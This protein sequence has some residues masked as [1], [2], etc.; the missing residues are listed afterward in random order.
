MKR[1]KLLSYL[2]IITILAFSFSMFVGCLP[3]I[4]VGYV[5][6]YYFTMAFEKAR[7]ERKLKKALKTEV[8]GSK[9]LLEN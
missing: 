7:A 9:K 5:S 1:I 6:G 8:K 4:V 3:W 2:F